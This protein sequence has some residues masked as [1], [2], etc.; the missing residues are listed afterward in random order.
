MKLDDIILNQY[1]ELSCTM[2]GTLTGFKLYLV[3]SS[4]VEYEFSQIPLQPNNDNAIDC[5]DQLI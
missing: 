2:D 5:R 1:N 4:E 3:D